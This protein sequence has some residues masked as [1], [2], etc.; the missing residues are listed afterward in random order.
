MRKSGKAEGNPK[1]LHRLTI[2][3]RNCCYHTSARLIK[4]LKQHMDE[5]EEATRPDDEEKRCYR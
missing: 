3:A 2:K 5:Q 1:K 4:C